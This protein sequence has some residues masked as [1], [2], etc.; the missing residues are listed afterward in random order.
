MRSTWRSWRRRRRQ[1]Q[2]QHR[3]R[4]TRPSRQKSTSTKTSKQI[5]HSVA[6]R[7]QRHMRRPC[8]FWAQQ[9]ARRKFRRRWCWPRPVT[10]TSMQRHRHMHATY[11]ST[12]PRR[13]QLRTVCT[14]TCRAQGMTIM[15]PLRTRHRLGCSRP[16]D[17]WTLPWP[18][19]HRPTFSARLV[20][21]THRPRMRPHPHPRLHL[22]HR[23]PAAPLAAG[24]F[25][26]RVRLAQ[27]QSHTH[28]APVCS[29]SHISTSRRA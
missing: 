19:T 27:P 1:W 5:A 7:M 6:L 11:P 12:L 13:S 25:R 2:Q 29:T 20:R 16:R 28:G 8:R 22:H 26:R 24:R 15:Q 23:P 18:Q 10:A 17:H 14:C 9:R 4:T 21:P 3:R